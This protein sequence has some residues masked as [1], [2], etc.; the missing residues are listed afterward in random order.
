MN[1][2]ETGWMEHARCR[3]PGA[4]YFW[5]CNS[6]K[7]KESKER[8]QSALNEC[9]Q[10]PVQW[11]CVEYAID[12]MDLWNIC[13]VEPDDREFLERLSNW[14]DLVIMAANCN[15]P[16]VELVRNLRTSATT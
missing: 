6:S 15:M 12:T 10:C 4:Y 13:A 1:N 5:C 7:T 8:R 3:Y 9:S 2:V 16:V 14:R 11:R